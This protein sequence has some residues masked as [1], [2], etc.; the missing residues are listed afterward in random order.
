MFGLLRRFWSDRRGNVAVLFGLAAVPI[1]GVMGVAV[2]Y[3]RA[4]HYRTLLQSAVDT[5]ALAGATATSNKAI[6][7]TVDSVMDA[8]LPGGSGPNG[9]HFNTDIDPDSVTVTA[10]AKVP[11]T[12][13]AI[14][15][16]NVPIKVSATAS[17]GTPVRAVD[18]SVTNFNADAWDANS[19]YWYIVPKDGSLPADTGLHLLLSNDPAHPAPTAPAS[20]QIGPEDEIGFA[21]INVTGGVHPYGANSYGQPQ[22]S[23]HKFYSQQLPENLHAA[24]YADCKSGTVQHAWD[25]NGGGSDDNDYNDAVYDFSC[26]TVTTDPKTIVLIR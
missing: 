7:D 10:R 12:I 24:G 9:M 23:V 16:S 20:V 1:I 25:D 19:I 5:A 6:R 14:F 22:G 26:N 2:D 21:M 8:T 15:R 11:T 18:I 3:S 13:A 17:R 4:S